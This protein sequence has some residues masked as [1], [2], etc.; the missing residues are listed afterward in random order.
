MPR[1]ILAAA[2]LFVAY[3]AGSFLGGLARVW[4]SKIEGLNPA[5]VGKAVRYGVLF[6][7]AV[8][9]M[10]KLYLTTTFLVAVFI[11]VFGA[12]MLTA[13][14]AFGN[15][16]ADPARDVV[17]RWLRKRRESGRRDDEE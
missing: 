5:V 9:A 8:M 6:V 10:E 13:A 15:A 11:I 16:F 17:S 7:G 4:A 1:L 2:I 14:I 3:V 12:V